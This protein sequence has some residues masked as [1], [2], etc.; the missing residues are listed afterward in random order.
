MTA[1]AVWDDPF[2]SRLSEGGSG[3]RTDSQ[4]SRTAITNAASNKPVTIPPAM[5]DDDIFMGNNRSTLINLSYF[6]LSFNVFVN[7]PHK[8]MKV[9]FARIKR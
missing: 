6:G 9:A 8:N 3:S 5:P 7:L 1:G 4:R 2:P